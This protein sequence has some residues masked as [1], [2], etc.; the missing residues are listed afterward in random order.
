MKFIGDNNI[1][2]LL[3]SVLMS[4]PSCIMALERESF[5]FGWR[6]FEGDVSDASAA[7]FDDRGWKSVTL[8]HDWDIFHA[9]SVD[10]ACGND[11]GYYPGGTGW[12]RKTFKAPKGER[13]VLHFEGVYQ[14]C[15]VFI[16]GR[17]AAFHG[18][19]Y[20]PFRVDV[21]DMIKP[22]NENVVSVKVDNSKQ[23]NCRWYSGSGIYR[24]VWLETSGKMRID[25]E[26]VFVT[27]LFDK[28]SDGK[29]ALDKV[30][31]NV[32]VTLVNMSE[33]TRVV[34]VSAL[35][36]SENVSL[37]KGEKK[38]VTLRS[39]VNNP[40]LWSPDTPVMNDV[41]VVVSENGKVVDRRVQKYG[42]RHIE[43]NSR[44]G[45]LLNG[46]PLLVNGACVH[47]DNGM[48]GAAAYDAA[49]ARKVRLMKDAGFNLIRTSH[50]PST[51][52]FM[53]A[54]DSIGMLVI[55]E[56]YD[57]WYSQKTKYDY[58]S[59]LDTTYVSD[60]SSMVMRDRNHPSVICWS[61]GN[62]VIER[63]EIRVIQTAQ[64]FKNT[65]LALDTT[66]PVTE[67]L[68][69]WDS[70][71]EIFDPHAAVLDIVGYNYMMHK[72]ESDHK[73][74]PQRVMWQTESYPREAFLNWK[75][76]S[77]NSYIL[78]DIV[79]TGLDYLGE[80]GIGQY[81]YEGE[82]RGEHYNGKHFP[83]HGTYCGDV[84]ITG[85][86]KPIS[87]YRD[88]L[89]NGVDGDAKGDEAVYLAVKEPDM[90]RNGKISETLWSV[91]P[92]WE[93]WNWKGWE[94]KRIEAEIYTKAPE[95]RLYLNDRL[96][97]TKKVS[98]ST[99]YKAVIPLDYQPGVLRAVAVSAD[100]KEGKSAVLRT[101][102]VAASVRLTPDRS[103]IKADGQDLCFCTVEV[104]D[105]DGNLVADANETLNVSVSG[106]AQLVAAASASLRDLEP[107]T[108]YKVTTFNGRA[109]VVLKS[110]VK[111]GACR[112][113]VGNE[114]IK[115]QT[116]VKIVR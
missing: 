104:V 13:V 110:S 109:L 3:F 72:H 14:N 115:G 114:A 34:A 97:A 1:K 96:V 41:E 95:V 105:K 83:F 113:T 58:H 81:Y 111:N 92:T 56:I 26:G 21:T 5:D 102:S 98:K 71:W 107:V 19:G 8:P 52:A 38:T 86:R 49:E 70:D 106:A 103:V 7:S 100:G 66:R 35:N 64:K 12:Y 68:C 65:I 32:A 24:H 73:R 45:L 18:Y 94:G 63:K 25:D 47:H 33:Q 51:R 43:Y 2:A 60:I 39:V 93:S 76:T 53:D 22:G 50:N 23:P 44:E 59:S 75:R 108:S 6:F 54:C 9:P 31:V 36:S 88:L 99:E 4:A 30:T 61:I 20:T 40:K 82:P 37:A 87:H 15:E 116:A 69:S 112:L 84:D 17:N 79:W 11:G 80:S 89:W 101:S 78:G 29:V 77:E 67:A 55:D 46:R 42:V 57:G 85:W 16:N 62:E 10:N 91:W 74:V 48:L 28:K 27:T 90:Y